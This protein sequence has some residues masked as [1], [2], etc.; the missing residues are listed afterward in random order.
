MME[1]RE[2]STSLNKE[3][4]EYLRGKSVCIV[5]RGGLEDVEQGEFIDSHDV[6]VRVH[7]MHPFNRKYPDGFVPIDGR[8]VSSIMAVPLEW[9]TR[10]GS[11][12]EI[13]FCGYVLD[14]GESEAFMKKCFAEHTQPFSANGGKFLCAAS[15]ENHHHYC[16]TVFREV[17]P[18][19]YLT[20]DHWLNTK[21]AIGGS[22]PYPGTLAVTDIL[23]H[24]VETVYLTGLPCFITE[25]NF[26][27]P[28]GR[29]KICPV[30]DLGFMVRLADL[31]P[32]KVTID[33]NMSRAWS[34]VKKHGI[35]GGRT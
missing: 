19:R 30:N 21:R 3:Y 18:I 17:H 9:R 24:E 25:D 33:D 5:G 15:W 23:R 31:H 2:R 10:V 26:D 7:D 29:V 35:K 8:S 16:E 27:D 1:F 13:L 4:A 6:V 22:D 20:M 32:D 11:K 34:Y 28:L 12:C 14:Q